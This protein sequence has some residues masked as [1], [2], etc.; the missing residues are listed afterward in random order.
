MPTP[1]DPKR[2]QVI[3]RIVT[4]LAAITAGATYFY[5]PAQVIKRYLDPEEV[6]DFPT[7]SVSYDSGGRLENSGEDLYDEDF[8][9]NVKGYVQDYEDTVTKMERALRDIRRAIN[10]DSKSGAAGSLG[11]LAVETRIE[12][13]AETDNGYYSLAGL[14]FFEQRIRVKIAGDYGD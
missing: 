8:Y 1:A 6:K 14:G 9:I 4:V 5:T 7:Y 13:G 12:D 10:E 3:D 2:L 11:V